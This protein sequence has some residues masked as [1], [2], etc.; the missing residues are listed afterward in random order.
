M[1]KYESHALIIIINIIISSIIFISIIIIN[2]I[3][4]NISLSSSS[5]SAIVIVIVI[6][7]IISAITVDSHT[8][9]SLPPPHALPALYA[10][11][12]ALHHQFNDT[13]PDEPLINKMQQKWRKIQKEKKYTEKKL[14][15]KCKNAA[16]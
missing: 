15:K 13:I 6:V 4:N 3:V 14:G 12:M 9:T 5:P 8:H 16:H 1:G 11:Q 7:I 10:R 2:I